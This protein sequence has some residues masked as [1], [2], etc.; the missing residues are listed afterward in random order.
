MLGYSQFPGSEGG[1]GTGPPVF[2][3]KG[4]GLA[5][6]ECLLLA[7]NPAAARCPGVCALE[8][9]CPSR[10]A[11]G[12][13]CHAWTRFYPCHLPCPPP[14]SRPSE[15]GSGT[16]ALPPD[17]VVPVGAEGSQQSPGQTDSGQC[18]HGVSDA[19]RS[20]RPRSSVLWRLL[21]GRPPSVPGAV[22]KPALHSTVRTSISR[23]K[24]SPGKTTLNCDASATVHSVSTAHPCL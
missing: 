9:T 16:P 5:L 24:D 22:R 8:G 23:R 7:A 3:T 4:L 14:R 6:S 12:W 18:R 1:C 19:G 17:P 15:E 2:L 21:S 20:R 11:S 13:D 10:T